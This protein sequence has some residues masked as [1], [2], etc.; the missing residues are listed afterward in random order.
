MQTFNS[1]DPQ[2]HIGKTDTWL[3]PLY[4]IESL[5]NDFDLDP[6]GF[7]KHKTAKNIYELPTCGLTNEWFGKVWLNPPYS[8]A[9]K[10]LDKMTIHRN[11]SVLIFS[12]TG[13]LQK[14]MKDCDHI[15]FLRK[16]IRFLDI[17]LNKAKYNPGCDSMI[18]SWGHQNFSKLDGLQIK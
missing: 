3:T 1:T 6:C 16:R 14:Y 4:I 18:L 10:W 12:R 17:D 15:F 8:D 2:S 5:G 11:G 13:T 9:H 7:A